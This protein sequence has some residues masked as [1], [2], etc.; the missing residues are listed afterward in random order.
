MGTVTVLLSSYNGEKYIA[1]Q[2]DSLLKQKDVDVKIV[3]RDDGSNDGTLAILEGYEKNNDSISIIKANNVGVT[4]SF[5]ELCHYALQNCYTDFY[6]FCDQD[7]YW[8]SEKLKVATD[9][10]LEYP[11]E[12]PNLYFSNLKMVDKELNFLGYQYHPG[13]VKIG[14]RYALIQLFTYGCTCVFNR[15]ALEKFCSASPQQLCHDHWIFELCTYYGNVY[16]DENSYILYRQHGN[17]VSGAKQR[18]ISLLKVRFHTFMV[19][20]LDHNFD[21]SANQ[22]LSLKGQMKEDDYQYVNRIAHYRENLKYKLGLLFSPSYRT[23]VLSK[24]LIIKFRILINKL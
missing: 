17:N 11:K 15:A 10:L 3:V 7:D 23:G 4:A 20:G 22:V 14:P 9:K 16:Y 21:V 1:E 13:E 19:K 6:A 12:K 8:E 24:D 5:N 18:G 2:I